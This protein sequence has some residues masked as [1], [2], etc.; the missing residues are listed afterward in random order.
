MKTEP[1]HIFKGLSLYKQPIT[2]RGGSPYWY[3]RVWMRIGDREVHTKSTGTTDVPSATKLAQAF[4]GDCLLLQ[5]GQ[6]PGLGSQITSSRR[7]DAIADEWLS[8]K[9]VMAGSDHRKLRACDDARK[10]INAPNGLGAFF[11]RIDVGSVTTG[12]V[13]DY[14]CFAAEHSKKGQL[15]TTTQRNHLSTLNAILKFAAERR[16]IAAAPPMPRLRLKDNP[17]PCFQDWEINELC[18]T[19]GVLK[20]WA[21]ESQDHSAA[22]EWQ[23]I[24][25]FVTFM[26]AT[27]LRAGEWKELRQKH[28]QVIHGPHPY[29][30]VVVPNGKTHKR[31]VVSMPEAIEV[32][33]SIV[34]RDGREPERFLFKARYANR[35][36]AKERMDDS[37]KALLKECH[38]ELDEF[39]NKRTIYSLRHT[40]LMM[41]LL[42]GK[43]VDLLMLARNAGTSVDQLER[44]YLSH[45]DPAM[46]VENLHSYKLKPAQVEEEESDFLAEPSHRIQLATS[47]S[48]PYQTSLD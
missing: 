47:S 20:R 8:Q 15:A 29:L 27:F 13:R 38:S 26:V 40:A 22:A 32:F 43:D 3:A 37:F 7:F 35:E 39:G 10:L 41:R 31:K 11:K 12:M 34:E 44:F 42:H 2:S 5:R 24:E 9:K 14:L 6:L 45:A 19:A 16:I 28:C 46:K 23:E 4:Y 17:R 48:E 1:I 25:D 18:L 36:T 21:T 30:E 33:E